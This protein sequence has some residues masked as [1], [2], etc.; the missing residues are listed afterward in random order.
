MD[1]ASVTGIWDVCVFCDTFLSLE[2]LRLPQPQTDW[3]RGRR[4]VWR[5]SGGSRRGGS[6]G[7]IVNWS[8][9][10]WETRVHTDMVGSCRALPLALSVSNNED[11]CAHVFVSRLGVWVVYCWTMRRRTEKASPAP[12][13]STSTSALTAVSPAVMFSASRVSARSPRTGRQTRPALSAARSSHTPTSTKVSFPH[14]WWTVLLLTDNSG[15][16]SKVSWHYN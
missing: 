14:T 16:N 9:S 6:D 8:R 10:R 11:V 15:N 12:C 7:C 3:A 4:T 5:V 1:S 13:V 2:P